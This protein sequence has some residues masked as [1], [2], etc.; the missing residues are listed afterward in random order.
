MRYA[1]LLYMDPIAAASTTLDEAEAEL[2]AYGEVTQQ[3]AAAGLL[4]GGEAFM[5]AQTATVVQG[6]D[7]QRSN[8]PVAATD[9]ELSGFY[10][11]DCE[12]GEAV[13]I[14]ARMPVVGHGAV[15]IRPLMDLPDPS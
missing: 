4:R 10:I 13:E 8:G 12:E 2:V 14:A 5:P 1:L 7:R 6:P 11:V 15:E 3:L 9:L